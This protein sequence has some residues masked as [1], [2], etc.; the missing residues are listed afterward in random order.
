MST[1]VFSIAPFQYLHVLNKNDNTKRLICGPIN[2]AIEDH[3]EI[4]SKV[5][6]KM[7]IIPNLHYVSIRDPIEKDKDGNI[8]ESDEVSI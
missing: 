7:I 2:F 6:E 4:V 8:L 3:E 1:K 5:P